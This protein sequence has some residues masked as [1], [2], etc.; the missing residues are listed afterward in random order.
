MRTAGEKR[1]KI[2]LSLEKIHL[3]FSIF[4]IIFDYI[5]S[6]SS[7]NLISMT[8]WKTMMMIF[9][10]TCLLTIQNLFHKV[11]TQTTGTIFHNDLLDGITNAAQ[12]RRGCADRQS[13]LR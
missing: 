5:I 10:K 4:F 1:E 9:S 12:V 13:S 8:I 11:Q 3:Y 2:R 6:R 7:D